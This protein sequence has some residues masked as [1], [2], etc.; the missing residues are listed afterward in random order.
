MQECYF[1]HEEDTEVLRTVCRCRT[2][3]SVCQSCL[4]NENFSENVECETCEAKCGKLLKKLR[5]EA[6]AGQGRQQ[7]GPMMTNMPMMPNPQMAMPYFMPPPQMMQQ[8]S[9]SQSFSK[10][11]DLLATKKKK[12]NGEMDDEAENCQ[13]YPQNYQHMQYPPNCMYGYQFPGYPMQPYGQFNPNYYFNPMMM[14]MQYP[15]HQANPEYQF[16]Q[17]MAQQQGR[18]PETKRFETEQEIKLRLA[19]KRSAERGIN[20]IKHSDDEEE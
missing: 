19:M 13:G 6:L 17:S 1:C 9:H 14:P 2:G 3:V 8:M 7:N 4:I 18:R 10:N 12:R 20:P 5:T 15:M 11:N 16:S